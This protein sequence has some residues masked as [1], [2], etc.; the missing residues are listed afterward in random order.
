MVNE[1]QASRPHEETIEAAWTALTASWDKEDAHLKFLAL[2]ETLGRLD[3]AGLHYR[4]VAESD[5]PQAEEAKKR[6]DQIMAVAMST[7]QALRKEPSRGARS[8]VLM[9]GVV[10]AVVLLT[11]AA[12]FFV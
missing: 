1:S 11:F 10:L 3:A 5:G 8:L 9:L 6:I 7:I 4:K 12:S 2:C